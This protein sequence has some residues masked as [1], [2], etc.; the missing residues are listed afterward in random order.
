[1][2][3]AVGITAVCSAS[4]TTSGYC[5]VPYGGERKKSRLHPIRLLCPF[6]IQKLHWKL[7]HEGAWFIQRA[8]SLLQSILSR[9]DISAT[10]LLRTVFPL[11]F[12]FA[13][14]YAFRVTYQSSQSIQTILQA[15]QVVS[16]HHPI[17]TCFHVIIII[18]LQRFSSFK[19][20]CR[21]TRNK[22]ITMSKN[23]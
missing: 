21:A 14:H 5:Y 6:K 16:Q 7:S 4:A 12:T 18:F 3:Q 1:M 19:W 2:S 13:L 10:C 15:F 23:R 20:L 8:T 22:R 11:L 17:G 9:M